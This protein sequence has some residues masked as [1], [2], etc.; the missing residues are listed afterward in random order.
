MKSIEL[1]AG[2]GGLGL[3]LHDAGFR[4]VSV[5]EWDDYCVDTIKE[6]QQRGMKAVKGW[7]VR[8]GDVRDVD[9]RSFEDKVVLV[10]GGPPCQPFSMGGKHA[11]YDD[12]RDMFPQ[13]IR[14]V[15][16]ARPRAFIFEN[17]KGLTRATFRNYFEYVRL[18][19]SHPE[20]IKGEDESWQ[21]HLSRLEQHHTSGSREGLNFRVATQLLNAANFGIPQ[22]RERVFFVGIREDLGKA[23]HF[24]HETHS[25]ESL[26]WDQV[27]G[28]YWD[29]HKVAK[30]DRPDIPAGARALGKDERPDEKPWCTVADALVDLPDPEKNRGND[31]LVHNHRYQPGARSYPGHT[32]SALHEPAKTLKAGVHGVPGGENM[33]RRPDGS[34]RYFTVRESARLQTFP[35]NYVFHGSWT[36]TMRQLGNAVPVDLAA[37]VGRSVASQIGA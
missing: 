11:A 14:A 22:K 10:S 23:W 24:P 3:G 12:H 5:Y 32:G 20:I 19:L 29:R 25:R 30:K 9:F 16:Q 15:R 17:V 28:D 18:Q 8:H 35:D 21:D 37:V 6:N 36:E 1:F 27:H 31:P 26:L 13:A 34:V 4:P 7:K 33:L 2:A